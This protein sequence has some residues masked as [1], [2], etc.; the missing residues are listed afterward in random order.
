M[1]EFFPDSRFPR[2]ACRGAISEPSL[3]NRR[4]ECRRT[5]VRHVLGSERRNAWR[6]SMRD[7]RM[8]VRHGAP[9]LTSL[10]WLAVFSAGLEAAPAVQSG[11][12]TVDDG[13]RVYFE[14]AGAEHAGV[15]IVLL[16][17]GM[18]SIDT[19][20]P[21]FI[22][23]FSRT[24]RV[25]AIEA[26]GHG[27]TADRDG[28]MTLERLAADV[29]GVLN[30]LGVPRADLVGHS[31]GGM[32]AT[33]VAIRRPER[34]RT[35]TVLSASYH[36]DGFLPELAAM[37]RDPALAPSPALVPLLPTERHFAE[38]TESYERNAP[39]PAALGRMLAKLNDLLVGW[40]GFG[41]A[42]LAAIAAPTLLVYGDRD[43]FTPG[44]IHAFVRLVPDA[45]LAIL[46]GTTHTEVIDRGA[47][48]VPMIEARIATS[49]ATAD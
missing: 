12:A 10:A 44:S 29:V 47:W 31:L 5:R 49:A 26:Q 34:V 6:S 45:R 4:S 37:N 21:D 14:V 25:I 46:P 18:M 19:A 35:L 27:H 1:G 13:H 41:E 3:Q 42:E 39:D 17:G 9:A 24:R 30:H 11:A 36:F 38:W 8:S 15:P 7:S 28:P 22:E 20:F 23:R 32:T 33:L 43:F 16:H 2:S 40:P 48:L